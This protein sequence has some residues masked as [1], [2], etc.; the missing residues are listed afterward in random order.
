MN[1]TTAGTKKRSWRDDMA[2]ASSKGK[3]PRDD[4]DED[5][6]E[7]ED[8]GA[9]AALQHELAEREKLKAQRS[10]EIEREAGYL[11]RTRGTHE[12]RGAFAYLDVEIGVRASWKAS[13]DAN[14]VT[15]RL[16]VELFDDVVPRTVRHFVG[17]VAG[18][19]GDRGGDGARRPALA[20]SAFSS[21]VPGVGCVGGDA[22]RAA[23]GAPGAGRAGG[24]A[25]GGRPFEAENFKLKHTNAGVLSLV[26]IATGR[27]GAARAG[28][29][30]PPPT[31]GARFAI[32]FAEAPQLDDR[33]VVFGRVAYGRK[34]LLEVRRRRRRPRASRARARIARRG[35]RARA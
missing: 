17:L 5:E 18:G 22:P 25:M 10:A 16:V 8:G 1:F 14:V 21:I 35:V 12:R 32:T 6:E 19:D 20:G 7:D 31:F 33:Q 29:R 15:G 11:S 23:P 34:L 9:F 28:G 27:G 30:E 4:D 13:A 24:G 26:P 2:K 3:R